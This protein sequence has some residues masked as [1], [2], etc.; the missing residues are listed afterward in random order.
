MFH[1]RFAKEGVL[2][3]AVGLDYRRKILEKA[4]T[5][6]AAVLLRDFLG[7][8]PTDDAFLKSKGL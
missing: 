7:R 8:D 1:S 3:P 2:N 6:D 4:S 5:E